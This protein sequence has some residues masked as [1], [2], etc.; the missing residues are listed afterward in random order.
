M[1]DGFIFYNDKTNIEK[2]MNNSKKLLS[3]YAV[4]NI[5]SKY[6]TLYDDSINE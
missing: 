2:M 4:E 6:L 3:K 5:L 1:E